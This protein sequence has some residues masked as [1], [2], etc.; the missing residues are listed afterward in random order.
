MPRRRPA[1]STMPYF[2]PD[3]EIELPPV[4]ADASSGRPILA[5]YPGPISFGPFTVDLAIARMFRD[6]VEFP[7]RPQVFRVLRFLIQNPGRLIDYE[8]MLRGAWAGARVSRHTVA[9]TVNELRNTLGEYGAW[10]SIRPGYGYSLEIPETEHLMRLGQH[11]RSQQTR[12]GLYNA[13]GCF[14]R[15][16]ALEGAGGRAWEELAG[17]YLQIGLLGARPARELQK[18]FSG[19]H[20]QA[21]AANG[22]TPRLRLQQALSL[23]LFEH[24]FAE[25]AYELSQLVDAVPAFLEARVCLA[26]IDFVC[27]RTGEALDELRTAEKTDVL[28]PLI[29]YVKPRI[30]LCS[31]ELTAAET[32]AKQAVALHPNAPIARINYAD[33]LDARGDDGAAAQYRTAR[34]IEPEVAW[35]RAAEARCLAR[36][37]ETKTALEILEQLETNRDAQYV[38]AYHMALLQEALGR[39]DTAFRE[40]E[41]AYEERSPMI[42]WLEC[43]NKS[44][45]IRKDPRFMDLRERVWSAPQSGS[46]LSA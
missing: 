37:G 11:F 27:G 39:R 10:I 16:A 42:A 22:G 9:V 4:P 24:S 6:G 38:D 3:L 13:I 36:R 23:F 45:S 30:L 15:V 14:E 44:D 1:N 33:V 17:A 40:L 2:Q 12:A 46:R 20:K 34:A 5:K 32:C 29:G 8:E 41:R 19:A 35:I 31:G 26:M 7:L 25:A 43:D 28:Y 18:A 21:S